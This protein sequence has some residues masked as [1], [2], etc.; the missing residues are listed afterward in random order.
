MQRRRT[1]RNETLGRRGAPDELVDEITRM[2][3]QEPLP[4][5][6]TVALE[7]ADPTRCQLPLSK[8]HPLCHDFCIRRMSSRPILCNERCRK[9]ITVK[10]I[11]TN[12]VY[13][14]FAALMRYFVN[15][16]GTLARVTL[17]LP[18]DDDLVSHLRT[19]QMV[20]QDPPGPLPDTWRTYSAAN[21]L[22]V[23]IQDV[24]FT[25]RDLLQYQ[26][27]RAF[28]SDHAYFTERARPDSYAEL[29]VILQL[30]RQVD[31][32][33]RI[34][35]GLRDKHR[36]RHAREDEYQTTGDR[37]AY[38]DY[39]YAPRHCPWPAALPAKPPVKPAKRHRFRGSL[40][41][42][43]RSQDGRESTSGVARSRFTTLEH[44]IRRS[45]H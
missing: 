10:D 19:W 23:A 27:A 26:T 2:S 32:R 41:R 38:R 44:E 29:C 34:P 45:T 9:W 33:I 13:S 20:F 25:K 35:Y 18:T 37:M 43:T 16:E 24:T 6:A 3:C 42:A 31:T 5:A 36:P 30:G 17:L 11:V 21:R 8:V 40:D 28:I 39:R 14:G 4:D 22:V 1:L 15:Q 7:H 12:Q